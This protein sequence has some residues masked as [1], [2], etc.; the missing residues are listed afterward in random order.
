[1]NKLT[2]SNF[3]ISAFRDIWIPNAKCLFATNPYVVHALERDGRLSEYED[4]KVAKVQRVTR[5]EFQYDHDFVDLKFHKY[6]QIL[7]HRLDE[8]HG[9]THGERFWDKALCLSILRHITQCYDLFKACEDN[10]DLTI[11]DCRVLDQSNYCVPND[12]DEHRKFF[13]DTD[14]GREQLFSVY[15]GLF[16]PGRFKSWVSPD[17]VYSLLRDRNTES[18][19]ERVR[20]F[21]ARFKPRKV[22]RGIGN[23]VRNILLSAFRQLGF[24]SI[25]VGIMD[26]SFSH[27]NVD[28]LVSESRGRIQPISCPVMPASTSN[29][30]FSQ[31]KFLVR[32]EPWFDRFDNFVF[33]SLLHG[34][35]KMYVED[36]LQTY[37]HFNS[38]FNRYSTMRWVVCEWWIGS[39]RSS[40]A[41]AVL[42]QR[43]VRHISVEHNYISHYFLGAN[44]KYL[45]P[46]ADE[47]ATLGWGDP[48]LPNIVRGASLF[49]WVENDIK[50]SKK[51]DILFLMT[52]PI[53]Y[54]AEMS[55]T[56]GGIDGAYGATIYFDWSRRF[57]AGL[58]DD[59][60]SKLYIRAYPLLAS[61]QWLVWDTALELKSFTGRVKAYDDDSSISARLLIQQSRLVVVNYTATSYLE[62][63]ISNIPTVF[64]WPKD[65]KFLSEK[66]T[67][68]FDE[69]I[70]VGI[71]QVN[72]EEAAAF[73]NRIKDSPEDWW[74]SAEVQKCRKKFLK[75]N[76]GDPEFM[77][78][79]L[80]EKAR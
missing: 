71:C 15:C 13:Q 6:M 37:A 51:H 70:N 69:L 54:M 80:L 9:T 49:Q 76:F 73:I 65:C 28:R 68:V 3:V 45:A 36:F 53:A 60:L 14:F 48:S 21:R 46:L 22:I 72:P 63:I 4:I 11:H 17:Y 42:S 44:L 31:R 8:L 1:M 24:S 64:F 59:A 20:H 12:F 10:L 23:R 27:Q 75:N 30:N 26:C 40:F 55:A 32:S 47:Y 18:L 66:Y 62:S 25:R 19:Q 74:N 41:T 58:G 56:Y 43:G 39:A 67:D 38:F 79:Y 34:M 16:Y 61:Q 50:S 78:Q 7:A 33:A 35:P 77:I 2:K 57:L 5:E 29:P 52:A